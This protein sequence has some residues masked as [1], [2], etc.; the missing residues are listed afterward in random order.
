V[1]SEV[2]LEVLDNGPGVPVALREKIFDMFFTTRQDA[3]GKGLGLS[4]SYRTAL[5]HGGRLEVEDA[6]GGGALFR[7]RLPRHKWTSAA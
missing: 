5:E 3:R 2:W 7:L 4:V 1:D 6:P